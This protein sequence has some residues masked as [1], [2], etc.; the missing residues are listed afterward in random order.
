M[1]MILSII[2]M[3]V[4]IVRLQPVFII[5]S[6][7]NFYFLI[8]IYSLELKIEEKLREKEAREQEFARDRLKGY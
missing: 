2:M 8:C 7:L 4:G 3:A 6:L 5:Y 1:T